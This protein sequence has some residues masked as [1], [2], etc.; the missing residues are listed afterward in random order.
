VRSQAASQRGDQVLD[1]GRRGRA[2]QRGRRGRCP[3]ER[4]QGPDVAV[5]QQFRNDVRVPGPAAGD[6]LVAG[7]DVAP[8]RAGRKAT[9][10]R[11]QGR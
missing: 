5:H 4:R 3:V 6:G 1:A 8:T 9:A 11:G 10:L 7:P 2:R